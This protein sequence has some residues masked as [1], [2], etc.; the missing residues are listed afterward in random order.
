ML[1]GDFLGPLD[2]VGFVASTLKLVIYDG[3]LAAEKANELGVKLTALSSG[4]MG[5]Q[6]LVY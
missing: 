3:E 4:A 1:S 2:A 5:V 6:G